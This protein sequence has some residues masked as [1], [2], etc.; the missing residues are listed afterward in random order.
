MLLQQAV[1]ENLRFLILE[2][3]KQ[4]HHTDEC[5]RES[6]F[7]LQ[8]KVLDRDNYIDNL[9]SLITE[10][11][12]DGAGGEPQLLAFFRASHA[13]ALNLERIADFCENVITQIGNLRN[14]AVLQEVDFSPSWA[15]IFG[16]V[17]RIEHALFER[18]LRLALKICHSEAELDRLYSQICTQVAKRMEG[19]DSAQAWLPV[20]SISHYLER[21]GDSLLN[22]GE[23]IASAC[24]G[25]QLK[26][27]ELQGLVEMEPQEP[28]EAFRLSGVGKTQ[29]G[30]R[31]S[32][33]E[34][35]RGKE[36]GERTVFIQGSRE[37]L[38][39][40]KRG[41]ELW[42]KR[43][44]GV[45]PRLISHTQN[46]HSA[47]I[48]CEFLSG[49]TFEKLLI[50]GSH[51]ELE[52]GLCSLSEALDSIWRDTSELRQI[53]STF[54]SQLSL[55]LPAIYAVHPHFQSKRRQLGALS[56]PNLEELL[57]RLMSLE[58]ELYAP[59]SVIGHGDFN[60]DNVIIGSDGEGIRLI[61]LHRS[62]PMD[63]LQDVSVFMVSN[64]RLRI[65]DLGTRARAKGVVLRFYH[66]A[67]EFAVSN[68]DEQ[69][70]LRLA[71]GLARSLIT[72]TR[73]VLDRGL[74]DSLFLRGRYLLERLSELSEPQYHS[75][76]IP[77]EA[78]FD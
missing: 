29:S 3:L 15:E 60:V 73:F 34:R 67:K 77:M 53:P 7:A 37:K 18:D 35:Q 24:L 26:L 51:L 41:I 56:L 45:A 30:C 64:L 70:D 65:L 69:F 43:V 9:K 57:E 2:V 4:L 52:Q 36:R 63:Y 42:N 58:R 1:K 32:I 40:E 68:G 28:L 74:A 16:G 11:C 71:L 5:L 76:E 14:R 66:F 75:Y 49:Q 21:M 59:F 44:P 33:L 22:I 6:N 55:R 13:T 23:A 38:I 78:L 25:H 72:S 50:S 17:E 62:R 48:L 19:S 20:L 12:F 31:I 10:T 39:G 8:R 54:L 27:D 46:D 47:S 61:D